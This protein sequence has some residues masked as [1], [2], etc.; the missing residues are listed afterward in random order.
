MRSRRIDQRTIRTR[1]G[2]FERGRTLHSGPF[3]SMFEA[4]RAGG[5]ERVIMQRIELPSGKALAGLVAE[6]KAILA[7]IFESDPELRRS[8]GTMTAKALEKTCRKAIEAQLYVYSELL[9]SLPAMRPEF[10]E[11]SED[12]VIFAFR[13]RRLAKMADHFAE[14]GNSSDENIEKVF[15]ST[16]KF[17]KSIFE[18]EPGGLIYPISP[19]NLP[20]DENGEVFPL[21]LFSCRFASPG[22]EKWQELFPAAMPESYVPPEGYEDERSEFYAFAALMYESLSGKRLQKAMDRAKSDGYVPLASMDESFPT[23]LDKTISFGLELLPERRFK[24]FEDMTAYVSGRGSSGISCLWPNGSPVSSLDL[25]PVTRGSQITET[26]RIRKNSG[27]SAIPF[28]ID[29][30]SAKWQKRPGEAAPVASHRTV[31]AGDG[32]IEAE[33]TFDFPRG[34]PEGVYEGIVRISTSYGSLEAPLSARAVSVPLWAKPPCGIVY[35]L[36]FAALFRL[37]GGLPAPEK[38]G[39]TFLYKSEWNEI[40]TIT[41]VSPKVCFSTES[42]EDW[43]AVPSGGKGASLAGGVLEIAGKKAKKYEKIGIV[44]AFFAPPATSFELSCTAVPAKPGSSKAGIKIFSSSGEH[45]SASIDPS[46]TVSFSSTGVPGKE[47]SPAKAHGSGIPIKISYSSAEYRIKCSVNGKWTA[48]FGEIEFSDLAV[49]MYGA[50]TSGNA[51]FS[52]RFTDMSIIPGAAIRRIPPY[53]A[54]ASRDE[55]ATEKASGGRATRT[56]KAGALVTVI[57][58]RGDKARTR[59]YGSGGGKTEGW[60]PRSSLRPPRPERLIP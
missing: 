7:E 4:R 20:V 30:I 19:E 6:N 1:P 17:L 35:A 55:P 51:D 26:I 9:K 40:K 29:V 18:S 54:E 22:K 49:C 5:G 25:G 39:R 52:W 23:G 2:V 28:T 13:H 53:T 56:V 45:V 24:S 60:I 11:K 36:L 47:N 58:E 15:E 16:L 42:P 12:S 3:A 27:I 14:S 50:G 48:E 31:R 34:I 21:D 43:K 59:P 8:F 44:S 38:F 32:E 41:A 10:V 33:V 37:A 57:E 46:G